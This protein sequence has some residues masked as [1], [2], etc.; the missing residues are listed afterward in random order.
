[1]AIAALALVGFCRH[2]G[3][4][5]NLEFVIQVPVFFSAQLQLIV[6]EALVLHFKVKGAKYYQAR[7]FSIAISYSSM[8]SLRGSP[9]YDAYQRESEDE[10]RSKSSKRVKDSS[11][12]ADRMGDSDEEFD[13]SN[14]GRGRDKF[15]RER[16][17]Y[18]DTSRGRRE[19]WSEENRQ[20][21]S[22][23]A[24]SR[25]RARG[26]RDN[27]GR[28]YSQRR[29]RYSPG[30]RSEGDPP[31]KRMRREWDDRGF[32][33]GGG[34]YSGDYNS[35]AQP[36]PGY[37][38][39]QNAPAPN[40]RENNSGGGDNY[41]TQPAMLTFK[42]FLAGLDD[43]VADT[44]AVQKYNE[45]KTTF[46]KD[47][48]L[49]FFNKHKE[50][51]WFKAKYHPDEFGRSKEAK[52]AYVHLRLKVFNELLEKDWIDSISIDVEKNLQI[53]K[54]LDAAVIKLEGGSDFDLGSLDVEYEET[55]KPSEPTLSMFTVDAEST[56]DV[57]AEP[58]DSAD[59]DVKL[60][61]Q[62]GDSDVKTEQVD[63]DVEA[64]M[65][66]KTEDDVEQESNGDEMKTE[67]TEPKKARHLHKTVSIFLRNISP[68]VSKRE[69]EE[70][71][72][73]I[74]GFMRLALAEPQAERRFY[75]RG[76][77]T[78]DRTVN[79]RDICWKFANNIKFGGVETGAI[80][81]RDL[82][83]RIRSVNGIA[84]HKNVV[85]A[86]IRHAAKIIHNLDKLRNLWQ[87]DVKKEEEQIEKKESTRP[88][89]GLESNNPLLQN[90]HDFMIEEAS[91]EEEELLGGE[92]GEIEE[93]E[94]ADGVVGTGQTLE[95]DEK[96]IKI[97]D[98][99]LLYL[100]IV[101][102]VDYYN[103]TDYPQEDDMPN[104]IGIMHARGS[105]PSSKVT[106]QEVNDYIKQFEAKIQPYL[107]LQT[108]ISDEEA[109][110]FG[111]QEP[112][113]E[114]EKFIEKNTEFISAGKYY[115]PLSKK[116]FKGPE[117]VRKHIE[118]KYAENLDDVRKDASYFNNY[119]MD[120]KRPQL[121]EHPSNRPQ[122]VP[123]QANS[124]REASAGAPAGPWPQHMGPYAP[125]YMGYGPPRA[126][127]PMAGFGGPI[128]SWQAP[129][130]A[131]GMPPVPYGRGK[132]NYRDWDA[133]DE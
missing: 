13:R 10:K 39:P 18:Q 27:Y 91:A 5:L 44:D 12:V 48:I 43:T 127:P 109:I 111:K 3:F 41:P 17:D 49:E 1:M 61:A 94:T 108:V 15:R 73:K 125:P 96:L 132:R 11:P 117:F 54:L 98:R 51:E 23:M 129:G 104:R 80:V 62:N 21:G 128:A 52:E 63:E 24:Q 28:D 29:D 120:P 31:M 25:D 4:Y 53:V 124:G 7:L 70:E 33:G 34:G 16:S 77:V 99:L 50:E 90:I 9:V 45:Y 20:A 26:G 118:N 86:D 116:K 64:K 32:G 106:Y 95:R 72:R 40:Q 110:K 55:V 119:L 105:P 65:A 57:D 69:I 76:W 71:C 37:G 68:T 30:D 8:S 6:S 133:P 38:F 114:V 81:N 22:W 47:Q 35:W 79:I 60:E 126:G 66:E 122:Q 19:E 78:F 92:V 102:S 123:G 67:P 36:E 84:S 14:R 88:D 100:R 130:R 59:T 42:Q 46:K 103:H 101:H 75:R 85:R 2:I 112:E 58:K 93:G 131:Y 82:S 87:D 113:V 74:P 89:Y 56:K 115:C 83:R 107:Q 121:P 97:L